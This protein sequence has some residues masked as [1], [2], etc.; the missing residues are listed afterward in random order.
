MNLSKYFTLIKFFIYI[1]QYSVYKVS[2]NL[3]YTKGM[4]VNIQA[5]SLSSKRFKKSNY[6]FWI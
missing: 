1:F 6:P 4:T 3:D 5:G 2:E